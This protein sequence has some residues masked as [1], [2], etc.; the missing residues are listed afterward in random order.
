MPITILNGRKK[1]NRESDYYNPTLARIARAELLD[2]LTQN[3]DRKTR[4]YAYKSLGYSESDAVLK[5]SP[6]LGRIRNFIK[7]I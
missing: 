5:S 1:R 2:D 6:L 7:N 4:E 3:K